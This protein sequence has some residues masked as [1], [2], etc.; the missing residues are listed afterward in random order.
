M[1]A[2][3]HLD[4]RLGEAVLDLLLEQ[5]GHHGGVAAQRDLALLVRVPS[6]TTVGLSFPGKTMPIV[7]FTS[8]F[9]QNIASLALARRIKAAYPHIA[10]VFGGANWEEE[11]GLELHHQFPFVDYVC[12]GEAER[13]FPTLVEQV[14]AQGPGAGEQ[15]CGCRLPNGDRVDLHR[16]AR[17]D[18]QPGRAPH[19]R[20]Q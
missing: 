4:A 10:I 1:R 12:S 5:L 8:T 11:M 15:H 20:L 9:E 16:P 7:G 19:P 13:S 6:S 3:M 17:T 18:P 2:S 14:L